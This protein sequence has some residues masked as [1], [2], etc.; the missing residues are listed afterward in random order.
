[1]L[2]KRLMRPRITIKTSAK[3]TNNCIKYVGPPCCRVKM[4]AGRVACCP[5]VSHGEYADETYRQTDRRTDAASVM[6]G[7][8]QL[9][10]L[11][12]IYHHYCYYCNVI[13]FHVSC[14]SAAD[15]LST[16]TRES[17]RSCISSV[18]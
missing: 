11:F 18:F 10:V 5:L 2:L 9:V 6:N 14:D 8:R 4:Y 17:K 16:F 1:M 12:D 13:S 15:I 7:H 3:S